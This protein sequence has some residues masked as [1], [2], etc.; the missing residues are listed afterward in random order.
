MPSRI[1]ADKK[2]RAK[3]VVKII[4]EARK[5]SKFMKFIREFIEYHTGTGKYSE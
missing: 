3:E 2:K 5:D 1:S 4:R